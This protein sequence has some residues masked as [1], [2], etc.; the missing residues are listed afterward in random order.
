MS[1][2]CDIP[3]GG[4]S[5]GSASLRAGAGENFY[6]LEY[7]QLESKAQSHYRGDL[8]LA[9]SGLAESPCSCQFC[10]VAAVSEVSLLCSQ[11]EKG[12]IEKK[13]GATA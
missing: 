13:A 8:T 3:Q 10:G 9:G 6:L 4:H 2:I 12:F 7:E 1:D 5:E 11:A